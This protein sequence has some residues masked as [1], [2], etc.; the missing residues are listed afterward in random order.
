MA[1]HF[2]EHKSPDGESVPP[3]LEDSS[4]ERV[5]NAW[6]SASEEPGGADSNPQVSAPEYSS[7]SDPDG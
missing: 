1:D 7:S 6:D 4:V 3:K 2:E 5:P